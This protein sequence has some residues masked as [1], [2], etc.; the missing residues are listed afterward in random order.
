MQNEREHENANGLSKLRHPCP[1]CGSHMQV[2]TSNSEFA[3]IRELYM[4]CTNHWECGFRAV[5]VLSID[6]VLAPSANPNPDLQVKTSP[7]LV[8]QVRLDL[9]DQPTAK[10]KKENA[11]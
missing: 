9:E 5:W 2:R 7:W 3:L 10:P 8:R 6:R 11:Q 1:H 4:F